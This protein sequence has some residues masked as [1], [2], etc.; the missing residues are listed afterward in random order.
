MSSIAKK[1]LL[2]KKYEKQLLSSF[3]NTKLTQTSRSVFTDRNEQVKKTNF[4]LE[5]IK[6]ADYFLHG[7]DNYTS[8]LVSLKIKSL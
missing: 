6:M 8:N 2:R 3:Q 4:V 7:H 5:L 1:R